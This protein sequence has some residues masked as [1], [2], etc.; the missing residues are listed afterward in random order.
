[1]RVARFA[2]PGILVVVIGV[3]V[4]FAVI[5]TSSHP[6]LTADSQALASIKLPTGGGT[7]QRIVATGGRQHR[8]IPVGIRDGKIYPTTQVN[9]GEKI[10]IT[11][12]VKRPSW[13]G[14]LA[15]K[16]QTMKLTVR[17]PT[18]KLHSRFVTRGSGKAVLI[19]YQEP[20]ASFGYG[21]VGSTIASH[22]TSGESNYKLNETDVAGTVSVEAAARSWEKPRRTTVSWFPG[23]AKATVVTSPAPGTQIQPTSTLKLTFS[24]PLAKVLGTSL[25][26][27]TPS[28]AGG[29]Q[30]INSHTIAYQPSGYGYGLSTNVSVALPSGVQIVGASSDATAA[31]W[32]VPQGTTMRLQQLLANLGYLPVNFTPKAT[33]ANTVGAQEA[34]AVTPP[35]GTFSWRYAETP[36]ALKQM[37][38]PGD[39]SEMMKGAVMAF[40]ND[41]GLAVDGIPGP[42]VWKALIGAS[43]KNEQSKFGYTFV[44]VTEGEP[45]HI[46][47][48]HSGKTVVSGPAN[49]GIPEAPTATG[50]FAVYEH[51]PSGT[52]SGTNPDGTPYHDTSIPWISYFNGGDAL[53]GFL[54]ASYGTRQS[55]GCVEMPYD[56]AGQVYPYTPIGTI[57]N[58]VS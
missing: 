7:V 47:V 22:A 4:A 27:V 1:M 38:T 34:A 9:G 24:K 30:K 37:W 21:K 40:E 52:M 57:V 14:W 10:T 11:A 46:D 13:I 54:R 6:K 41:Q 19:S 12:T 32:S 35:Q 56:E 20:V 43:I 36:T 8:V 18:A 2:V 33:V 50:T 31:T 26:V 15:G 5:V 25:P 16:S 45:E 29:W 17:T 28:S 44:Y 53:H 48:W 51:M 58:I 23:G 49:T 39:W 55:L 42:Q 3:I